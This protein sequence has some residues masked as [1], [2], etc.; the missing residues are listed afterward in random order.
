MTGM[1]RPLVATP[2]PFSRDTETR[3]GRTSPLLRGPTQ[4]PHEEEVAALQARRTASRLHRGSEDM[5]EWS[6]AEFQIP[7]E[8]MSPPWPFPSTPVQSTV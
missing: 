8:R 6:N 4:G 3:G 2:F 5:S 7:A 1:T